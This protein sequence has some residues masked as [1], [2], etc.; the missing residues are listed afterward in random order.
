[1]TTPRGSHR[2]SPSAK[3]AL[4]RG[5]YSAPVSAGGSKVG[6]KA[7]S[8]RGSR[9]MKNNKTVGGAG[10]YVSGTTTAGELTSGSNENS[11]SDEYSGGSNE[12]ADERSRQ[13]KQGRPSPQPYRGMAAAQQQTVRTGGVNKQTYYDRNVNQANDRHVLN[14]NNVDDLECKLVRFAS[15]NEESRDSEMMERFTRNAE[16]QEQE[17]RDAVDVSSLKAQ[18]GAGFAG[19]RDVKGR[20]MMD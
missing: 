3:E 19:F 8:R 9:D 16:L 17:A 11:N 6:S 14:A 10:G 15:K 1:M 2:S 7:S 20:Q 18:I 13:G 5:A 4:Y 12:Y